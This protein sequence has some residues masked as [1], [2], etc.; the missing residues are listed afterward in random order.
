MGAHGKGGAVFRSLWGRAHRLDAEIFRHRV[1]GF[2]PSLRVPLCSRC[3]GSN[4][5][6][7]P[8]LPGAGPP[9]MRSRNVVRRTFEV[10]VLA[11]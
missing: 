6:F 8:G 7:P 10:L 11:W 9:A 5:R 1:S 3:H 4:R 2:G